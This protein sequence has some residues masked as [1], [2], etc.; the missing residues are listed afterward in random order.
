LP[1]SG[2]HA[3]IH[4]VKRPWP[5]LSVR[6]AV[7]PGVFLLAVAAA[8][9]AGLPGS[10]DGSAAFLL[11]AAAAALVAAWAE[12]RCA[13]LRDRLRRLERRVRDDARRHERDMALAVEVH[14]SLIPPAA[15]A[16]PFSVHLRY[17]P[18]EEVGGDMACYHL[19]PARGIARVAIGDVTGHG[20]PAALLVNRIHHEVEEL[21]R[22]DAPPE[23]V[24]RAVN[25]LVA[26]TFRGTEM[27]MTFA[28]AE[29]RLDAAG[30]GR[31]T[32][33]N[34]AHPPPF[35]WRAQ[36]R[37]ITL[38][39]AQTALLGMDDHLRL[40]GPL[41]TEPVALGD[42]LILHTDG[43]IDAL[44]PA[45]K[46]FGLDR[47]VAAAADLAGHDPDLIASELI[48]RVQQHVRGPAQDDVLVLTL[49]IGAES[50]PAA[51]A[52]A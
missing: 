37:A 12:L 14:N 15:V 45:G 16:P 48:Q 43:L 5:S 40:D 50:P 3:I 49:A 20:L 38:L 30:R 23:A 27:L 33:A 46:R 2:P 22:R 7:L 39:N 19:D 13:R 10:P 42:R 29:V 11:A 35:L 24:L 18:L 32:C 17:L 25:A 31:C 44:D 34:A 21:L 6:T 9:V 51:P 36:T 4:A 52:R 41:E 26:R 28:V 47:L 8:A 1:S